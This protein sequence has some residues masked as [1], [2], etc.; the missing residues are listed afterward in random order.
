MRVGAVGVLE[1]RRPPTARII[2]DA[3]TLDLDDV[4][5]KVGKDLPAPGAR[6]HAAHIQNAKMRQRA[7]RRR[8]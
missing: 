4:R 6:K 7:V 8:W 3:R 1:V 5:T 2:A